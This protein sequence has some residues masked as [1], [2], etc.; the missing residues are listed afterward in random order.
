MIEAAILGLIRYRTGLTPIVYMA[1]TCSEIRRIP[2]SAAMPD[3]ARA[4]IMMAVRTGPISLT[5]VR[6]MADPR[7][8]TEPNFT[9]V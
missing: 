8:P 5:R 1:S 6:E 9:K 2:I 4:A 7:A 3:P